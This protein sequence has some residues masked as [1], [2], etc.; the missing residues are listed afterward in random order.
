MNVIK[1]KYRISNETDIEKKIS[2]QIEPVI[3]NLGFLIVQVK[4]LKHESVLQVMVEKN[5]SELNVSDCSKISKNILPLIEI[6]NL[7]PDDY[8][9]EISS[10]GIDRL[11]VRHK[12]FEDN[13]G[14]EIKIELNSSVEY[15]KKFKGFINGLDNKNIKIK[16]K[17]NKN[18]E[19]E[20]V[21]IPIEKINKAK[22]IMNN[23]LLK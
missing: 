15:K 11:L 19:Y 1:N 18:A 8:R 21:I 3:E 9:L 2:D 4:I 14:N 12:D 5:H 13:I 6:N 16:T 20:L 17:K 7:L 22:L 23:N 10:P